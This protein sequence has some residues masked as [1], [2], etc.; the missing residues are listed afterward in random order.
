MSQDPMY[1]ADSKEFRVKQTN[2]FAV[3]DQAKK[4]LESKIKNTV[5]PNVQEILRNDRAERGRSRRSLTRQYRGKDSLFA[6]PEIPPWRILVKNKVPDYILHPHRW[7]KYSLADVNDMNDKSNAAAAL[8]FLKEMEFRK[9]LDDEG[10]Q[11]S[12]EEKERILFKRIH[13][14]EPA[15]F[16][17]VKPS[18][19]NFKLVMPQYEFGKKIQKKK[20]VP[21]GK[22]DDTTSKCQQIK[23]GHLMEDETDE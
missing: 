6:K 20:T 13:S 4:D 22:P 5:A 2:M 3:L 17:E 18:F 10:D 1:L 11:I 16:P 23:L 12:N 14:I 9:F 21:M 19:K 7:T 8:A 15:E